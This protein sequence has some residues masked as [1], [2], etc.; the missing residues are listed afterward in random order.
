MYERIEGKGFGR[1]T[2]D[3]FS[4]V[5]LR[6]YSRRQGAGELVPF[7][8]SGY[9]AYAASN[10]G[11]KGDGGYGGGGSSGYGQTGSGKLSR[12]SRRLCVKTTKNGVF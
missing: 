2:R 7:P 6:S 9:G 3:V 11:K 8:S 12:N 1:N 5:G 10:Q 4:S